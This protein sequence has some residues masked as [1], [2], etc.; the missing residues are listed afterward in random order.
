MTLTR[1]EFRRTIFTFAVVASV[2]CT[3]PV[4]AQQQEDTQRTISFGLGLG[5]IAESGSDLSPLGLA[6]FEFPA[7]RQ[8]RIRVDGLFAATP[9]LSGT[10]L[11][12]LTANLL[13]AH[14][15]GNIEPYL[16]GGIGGYA[17]PGSRLSFGVNGGVGIRASAGRFR[18][19]AELREHVWFSSGGGRRA[20]PLT[21]GLT[22]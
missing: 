7:W 17:Q 15:T 13:Y 3:L 12:S 18:P 11:T 6:T 19:F 16:L 5:T 9:R 22:F 1:F 4:K 8:T 2:V 21:I 20:T 14:K 10:R